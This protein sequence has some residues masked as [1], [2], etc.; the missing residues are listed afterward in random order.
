MTEQREVRVVAL[1]MAALTLAAGVVAG[2]SVPASKD[3]SETLQQEGADP[4]SLPAGAVRP[5]GTM[6]NGLLPEQWGDTS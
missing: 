2:C 1:A 4:T 6:S 3:L 5:D